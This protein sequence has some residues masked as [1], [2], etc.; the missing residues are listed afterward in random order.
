MSNIDKRLNWTLK[1]LQI[2]RPNQNKWLV[3]TLVLS[4]VAVIVK[5]WWEPLIM[6]IFGKHG[7]STPDTSWVGWGLL[8]LGIGIHLLNRYQDHIGIGKSLDEFGVPTIP[9]AINNLN[10]LSEEFGEKI[11]RFRDEQNI[12]EDELASLLDE[13]LADGTISNWENGREFPADV[14]PQLLD[15]LGIVDSD[16]D[17]FALKHISG[18]DLALLKKKTNEKKSLQKN[19][20]LLRRTMLL[21]A[22]DRTEPIYII[23][24]YSSL[25]SQFRDQ[26]SPNYVFVDNLGDRDSLLDITITLARLYP[27]APIRFYHSEKFST[28]LLENDLILIGGIGYP[29]TPNNHVAKTL[30]EDMNIPLRYDGDTLFFGQ[31]Q[32]SSGYT[33]GTLTF[34]VGF[35]AN[36]KNP[37]NKAKR[38]LSIQGVHTSGVLGCVRAFSLNPAAVENHKLAQKI[39]GTREYCAIFPIRLFGSRPVIPN[40]KESDFFELP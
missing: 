29:E 9:Q 4:G 31:K 10:L 8:A 7:Y 23:A 28:R 35:F 5:P 15:I 24:P 14:L 12:S 22:E 13:D 3:S 25:N 6:A 2:V 30:I 36:V 34:D 18:A 40:L 16:F 26:S 1:F 21:G 38:V 11:S 39:F 20:A 37:W 32:W 27:L 33:D 19:I 17:A